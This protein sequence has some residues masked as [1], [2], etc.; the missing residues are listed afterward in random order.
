MEL[1]SLD[2]LDRDCIRITYICIRKIHKATL[3][4]TPSLNRFRFDDRYCP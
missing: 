1:E 2:Y 3:R 4:A